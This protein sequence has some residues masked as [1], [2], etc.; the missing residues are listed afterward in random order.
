MH[1]RNTST[2][3]AGICPWQTTTVWSVKCVSVT[4]VYC[5]RVRLQ[6]M[7]NRGRRA[8]IAQWSSRTL[9]KLPVPKLSPPSP[10][11]PVISAPLIGSALSL[12]KWAAQLNPALL[13]DTHAGFTHQGRGLKGFCHFSYYF[14]SL[15]QKSNENK[16]LYITSYTGNKTQREH[17]LKNNCNE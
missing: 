8:D 15:E 4:S 13:D 3:H 5:Q 11:I 14:L 10:S 9:P 12:Q 17:K 1:S 2:E 7:R 6:W 16:I